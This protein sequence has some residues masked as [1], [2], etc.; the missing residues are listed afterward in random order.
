[1]NETHRL[2]PEA[3]EA[4]LHGRWGPAVPEDYGL[5][6][7]ATVTDSGGV[8]LKVVLERSRDSLPVRTLV[9]DV[10]LPSGSTL[11]LSNLRNVFNVT[12]R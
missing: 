11:T 9:P 7:Q 3:I 8:V 10:E 5:S 1:M 2:T 4:L 6:I 12:M